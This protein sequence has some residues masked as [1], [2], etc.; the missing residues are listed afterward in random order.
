[1]PAIGETTRQT[2]PGPLV[3]PRAGESR[4]EQWALP[5]DA[6]SAGS[7]RVRLL[8]LPMSARDFRGDLG[9]HRTEG[10]PV[11]DQTSPQQKEG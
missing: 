1:M 3:R 8:S 10:Q 9:T 7:Q 11:C 4:G 5:T 6:G 2:A